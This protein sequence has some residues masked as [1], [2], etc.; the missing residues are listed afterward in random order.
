MT[1]LQQSYDHTQ[2]RGRSIDALQVGADGVR[3]DGRGHRGGFLFEGEGRL[4]NRRID[5]LWK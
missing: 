4:T 2:A 3:D 1:R 5:I